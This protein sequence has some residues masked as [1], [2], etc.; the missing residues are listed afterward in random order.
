M[1]AAKLRLDDAVDMREEGGLIIIQPVRQKCYDLAVL[2]S[3]ITSRNLHAETDFG[4]P[5]GKEI[6]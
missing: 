3:G 4:P 5:V 6:R 2:L 1:D